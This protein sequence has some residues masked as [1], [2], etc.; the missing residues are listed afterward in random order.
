[1]GV[2]ISYGRKKEM[3]KEFVYKKGSVVVKTKLGKVRGYAYNG[4]SVFK[5]IP[6]AK[7]KRFH[8]PEPLEAWEGELDATSFGY[9]CPLLEM[10]KPCG[11]IFV[12]HRYWIMDEDCLNL[13]IWTPACDDKARPILIWLHGGGFEAGS[14]IEHIAYEG[15]NMSRRGDA[16]VVSVNHR[17]NVL[18]YFDL[19]AFGQEYANSGNAGM[20]DI[21]ASLKWVQENIKKFGGDP[22]N[23]TVFGQSGGGAKVTT[24]L[25]MPAADGLFAKGIN[26]SGVIGD[27]MPKRGQSGKELAEA[28]MEELN[29]SSVK[30]LEAVPYAQLAAAYLKV[31][32]SFQAQGKYSGSLPIPNAYYVGDPGDV[33]FRKE[34]SNV[35]LMVGSVF[36]EFF[37]FA[38]MPFDRNHL[39]KE[40][41]EK[42][43]AQ[44]M[45]EAAASELLPLFEKAYP[46]HNPVDL[47]VLDCIVRAPILSY[48]K[49]RSKVNN[50]TYSYLFDLDLPLD[51]GWVPWHCADIPYV[52]ANTS[53]TPYTQEEGVTERIEKEI[54][55]SVM[56]FARTGN[57]NHAGI[58]NWPA[59]TPDQVYTLVTSK[60]T[61]VECNY[62]NELMETILNYRPSDL[63]N[64]TEEDGQIQH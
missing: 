42:A 59:C 41:G 60:N 61:R 27:L 38:P 3:E 63:S 53:C 49:E 23:V 51:G 25:Q 48:V 9:V 46:A 12:P 36:G 57:P 20:D 7:A 31:R 64:R 5:G 62:D 17:L 47:T 55:E 11:E 6:Y 18:G 16:V 52:F 13:N 8:A 58:P 21:I 45:G 44:V 56:A 40:E 54:F 50:Q 2:E 24:L 32:P 29:V 1:M 28:V 34:S 33:G 22:K 19:S 43:V 4:V 10:P 14:S 37:A 26:M 15:E 35:P 39:T 30:E